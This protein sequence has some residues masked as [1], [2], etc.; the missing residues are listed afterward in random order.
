MRVYP[1]IFLWQDLKTG[2]VWL[3]YLR[4]G[5]FRWPDFFVHQGWCNF[6][7]HDAISSFTFTKWPKIYGAIGVK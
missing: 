4:L 7:S 6:D 2:E 1:Q 3:K 5:Y